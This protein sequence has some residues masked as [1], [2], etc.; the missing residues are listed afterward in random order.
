MFAVFPRRP[1]EE[2]THLPPIG[3]RVRFPFGLTTLEGIVVEWR[4]PL[5]V[6]GGEVIRIEYEIPG[7]EGLRETEVG[8][9]ELEIIEPAA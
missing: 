7:V 5:D 4:G 8:L 3:T 2:T 1:P 9:D 6:G